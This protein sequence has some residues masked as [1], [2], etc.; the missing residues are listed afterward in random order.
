[1]AKTTKKDFELF[2]KEVNKW[3]EIIGLK[4][5]ECVFADDSADYGT[6]AQ[7]MVDLIGGISTYFFAG[8]WDGNANKISNR[9]VK[10]VGFHEVMEVMLWELAAMAKM[11]VNEEV[12]EKEV[13]KIIR[14]LEN[15]LFQKY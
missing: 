4:E 15:S 14:R 6:R 2:K 8:D 9:E 12:V 7:V 1:M 11:Y 13:H 3:I 5:F 10:I